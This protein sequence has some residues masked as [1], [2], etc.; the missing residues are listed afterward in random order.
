MRAYLY[1][2]TILIRRINQ[3]TRSNLVI[4]PA[5]EILIKL[6]ALVVATAEDRLSTTHPMSNS[7]EIVDIKSSQ[8]KKEY[9]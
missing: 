2:L 3:I 1:S 4:L 9:K 8:K 5:Q 7:S 6:A